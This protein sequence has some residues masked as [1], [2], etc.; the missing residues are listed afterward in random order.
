MVIICSVSVIATN[1]YWIEMTEVWFCA[2][3]E[4]EQT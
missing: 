3:G 1:K 2:M 4:N